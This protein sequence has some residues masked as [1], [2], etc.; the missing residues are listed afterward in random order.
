[1][2]STYNT[3]KQQPIFDSQEFCSKL[4]TTCQNPFNQP[5]YMITI[6]IWHLSWVIVLRDQMDSQFRYGAVNCRKYQIA[7]EE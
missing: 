6:V 4:P 2:L 5:F 1:M 3:S 7:L